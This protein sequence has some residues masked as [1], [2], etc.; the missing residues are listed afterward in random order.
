MNINFDIKI[1]F[2]LHFQCCREVAEKYPEITY[3]EVV[4]DNCCMMVY[5]FS[6][7]LFNLCKDICKCI[8]VGC[9][10]RT[11]VAYTF[12][13]IVV[14]LQHHDQS[15]EEKKFIIR[16]YVNS[17][18]KAHCYLVADSS[19]SPSFVLIVLGFIAVTAL[20]PYYSKTYK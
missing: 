11:V 12:S 13:M 10:Y 15:H 16:M 17:G 9:I 1:W 18:L 5:K 6:L 2:L 3:E 19:F 7:V 8:D 20:L 4:I 14:F